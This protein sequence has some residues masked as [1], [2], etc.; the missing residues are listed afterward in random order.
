MPRPD[1]RYPARVAALGYYG[2][3]NLGDEAVLAGIRRSL[4]IEGVDTEFLVLSNDPTDT[5]RLHAGVR[6]V[7]RWK[8]RETASALKG[9]DL[10][11]LGGGSL[12]Q[13]ATSVQSVV[14]YTLM[15]LMARRRARRVLWWGQGIGPLNA[16]LSRRLVGMIANQ[17]NALSVRDDDSARL[18][19]DVGV[20]G[21]ILSVADPAFALEPSPFPVSSN[22]KKDVSPSD[23]NS[24]VFVALRAWKTD[25]FGKAVATEQ[26]FT[27]LLSRATGNAPVQALP[28]HLPAD[29]DYVR[30]L[31]GGAAVSVEDWRAAGEGPEQVLA[32]VT[33]A[34]LMVA[35][36]LHALIFAARCGVPFVAVSYDPKVDALAKAAGQEDALVSLE[37]LTAPRLVE[38]LERVGATAQ[39][40]RQSLL[41]F[42]EEQRDLARAPARLARELL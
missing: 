12:L 10:F 4:Q 6:A 34:R 39:A 2:F 42:A 29:K 16:P 22:Y 8:W 1:T 17:A 35:M 7:N 31:P 36:R 26:D 5:E 25:D 20:R 30:G 19:K 37:G 9:T 23:A 11:I 33:R 27:A 18:L 3:G 32:R 24:P 13:D 15:A 40:R 41:A 28:M 21:S 38:A 14:W